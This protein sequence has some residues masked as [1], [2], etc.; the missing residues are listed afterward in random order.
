MTGQ[1][2]QGY[3]K[4]KNRLRVRIT[5][6]N[7][8]LLLPV[9]AAICAAALTT[10]YIQL[11]AFNVQLLLNESYN[12]QIYVMDQLS[13]SQQDYA[14]LLDTVAPYFCK[15]ISEAVKTRVQIYDSSM[16]LLAD[17]SY[18]HTLPVT[19]DVSTAAVQ[20]KAYTY[21]RF[22]NR[23]YISFSSPIYEGTTIIGVIRYLYVQQNLAVVSTLGAVLLVVSLAAMAFSYL[24]SR[25]SAKEINAPVRALQHA[26]DQSLSGKASAALPQMAEQE[27]Q[28]LLDRFTALRRSNENALS[29]LHEEKER[30]NLFF[31]SATHQLKTPLT[32]IIGY[33]E[34]VQ[35]LTQDGEIIQSAQYIESAGKNLLDV[36]ENIINI[37]R[38]QKVEVQI[39]PSWFYLDELCEHCA[40]LLKP[41]LERSGIALNNRCGH[42]HVYCD[43]QRMKEAVLNVLDNC[44][45]HARC[46]QILITSGTWPVSLMIQDNGVGVAPDKMDQLFMPFRRL[47]E[48]GARGTGLGLAICK[49]I[50]QA[51]GGEV[52]AQPVSPS[53]LCIVLQLGQA[54]A[55]PPERRRL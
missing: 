41:R 51:Q 28:H 44:I 13:G 4:P 38:Y 18:T 40:Q 27:Y 21:T 37:S 55:P 24:I 31:N 11:R 1:G 20:S 16:N 10:I 32:A 42:L 14:G 50:L 35:R 17:S 19:Q 52:I 5:T 22:Q 9:I 25:I 8:L 15:N 12:S 36:V 7:L 34:I 54:M 47:S 49:S 23:P 33:S 29:A 26:I 39:E 3:K 46:S 2:V 30:Q 45:L 43:Y 48:G 53:G 6:V